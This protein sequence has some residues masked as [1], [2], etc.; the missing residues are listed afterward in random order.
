MLPNRIVARFADGRML[1]GTTQ[2][3]APA[4]DTFHVIGSEGGSRPVKVAVE[5]LKAVFFVK[6]LVGNAAYTELKEFGGPAPGR[7]V[8]VTFKDGEV[9]VGS[10][11]GYQQDRPG[12][13]LV[14]ADPRSNN[15]RIYVVTT[16]VEKVS[17]LS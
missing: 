7:K 9:L 14:P 10:T 2:D 16:A 8:Q 3:F 15:D 13:F 12:F 11:Q 6:S 4:K 1:K 5:D 17:F